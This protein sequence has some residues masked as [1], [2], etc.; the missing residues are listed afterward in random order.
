MAEPL[1]TPP[2]KR[3][4]CARCGEKNRTFALSRFASIGLAET[5]AP[6]VDAVGADQAFSLRWLRLTEDG[7]WLLQVHDENECGSTVRSLTTQRRRWSRCARA[8]SHA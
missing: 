8:Y 3:Q 6:G 7:A 2:E 5:T 1:H 4:A